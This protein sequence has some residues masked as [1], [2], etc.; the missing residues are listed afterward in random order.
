MNVL[1]TGGAGFIGSHIVDELLRRGHQVAVL[2]NLSTGNIRFV[3]RNARFYQTDIVRDPLERIFSV[4]RPQAIVHQAAQVDVGKSLQNPFYDAQNNILGTIRLLMLAARF[5]VKKFIY[6][7]SCAVYGETGDIRIAETEPL[8]PISL[9]GIS[10]GTPEMY[11]RLFHK[12]HG[13]R[14]MILRYANVYGPRQTSK[15]EGGVVSIFL[16][17]LLQHKRPTIYGDGN[18]TRDFVYVKD[19]A[20]ANAAAL[21]HTANETVNIGCD[22]KT[23]VRQLYDMIANLIGTDLEPRYADA[24]KGDIRHSRLSIEKA[25]RVLG[26]RPSYSLEHGLKET[27]RHFQASDKERMIQ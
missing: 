25:Q 15:G 9:Y 12:W 7:S 3:N 14:Y 6:A 4:E 19:V 27:L 21:E 26:W 22:Q 10:K 1:V 23:S 8:Q 16:P 24:R 13:L 17:K 11:I 18:Q 5:D 2:D 20:G